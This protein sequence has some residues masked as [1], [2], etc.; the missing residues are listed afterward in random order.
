VS[1]FNG[2][3]EGFHLPDG[4]GHSRVQPHFMRIDSDKPSAVVAF[5]LS[6]HD[7]SSHADLRC[8]HDLV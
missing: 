5:E 4:I 3:Q 6:S 7:D 2:I 1:T 8:Q